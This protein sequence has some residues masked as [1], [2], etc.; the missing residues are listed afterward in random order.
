MNF[1]KSLAR[2]NPFVILLYKAI[3][4][5]LKYPKFFI[6]FKKFQ[7]LGAKD[8]FSVNWTDRYPCFDEGTKFTEFDRHYIYHTAWAARI[9]AKIKPLEHVDISSF[10]YFS[11]IVSAFIP[12]HFYD[13]RPAEIKLPN[14]QMG[15][16]D[17]LKLP[18]AN[19]SISSIS[20]MHVIEHI[21]LGRYGEPLDPDGDLKAISELKRVLAKGGNLLF[22]VPIGKPRI[23]FNAHK[24]YSYAQILS[25]FQGLNLVEFT[26]ISGHSNNNKEGLILNPSSNLIEQEEYACGCFWFGKD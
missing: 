14:L 8:R 25:Y 20:C 13:Y 23:M 12:V 18:F 3:L 11:T 7:E 5:L 17:L 26:L 2:K 21:G 4:S 9:L 22:V 10:L 19:D 16:T 6:D 15:R 24:I 1:L